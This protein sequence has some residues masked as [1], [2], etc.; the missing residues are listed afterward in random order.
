MRYPEQVYAALASSAPLRSNLVDGQGWD[1]ASFWQVVSRTASPLAG[2]APGFVPNSRAAFAALADLARSEEG[3]AQAGA[4]LRLCE[5]V[6]ATRA[7]ATTV[8]LWL[9]NAFDTAAMSSYAY[10]S[11]YF[12]GR[13]GHWVGWEGAGA[14]PRAARAAPKRLSPCPL[15]LRPAGDPM[16]PLPAWPMRAA[17]EELAGD[18]SDAEEL[19]SVHSRGGSSWA[20]AGWGQRDLETRH[21][22]GTPLLCNALALPNAAGPP[23]RRRWG[24]RQA[25]CGTP[26]RTKRATTLRLCCRGHGRRAARMC[27]KSA[28]SLYLTKRSFPQ[29]QAPCFGMR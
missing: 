10:P 6:L 13:L 1:P 12:T 15:C 16:H 28:P 18:L 4:A 23:C 29:T 5:G 11:S 7:N 14:C 26:Q 27:S 22:R 8:A 19:L 20:A 3:R 21:A 25:W 9:R 2:A 24:G 17:C